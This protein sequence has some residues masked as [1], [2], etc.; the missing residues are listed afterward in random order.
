MAYIERESAI[1][2]LLNHS[3][4]Q[5][6]YSREDAADCIRFMDAADVAP[7]RH[8]RWITTSGEFFPGSNQFLCYS[9][10]HEECG[11]QV[12]FS[13]NIIFLAVVKITIRV[14]HYTGLA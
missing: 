3:P 7:E 8:G 11:F 6:S 14:E 5:V 10:K 1:N 2:S 4:E 9:H 12:F 13:V